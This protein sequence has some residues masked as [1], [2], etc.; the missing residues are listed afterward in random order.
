M[1]DRT[2]DQI[3]DEMI[4]DISEG[5]DGTDVRAGIIGEI[6]T[7][8]PVAD[9]E[10]KVL[11]AAAH[12]QKTT[13]VALNVHVNW[14]GKHGI[15]AIRLLE[16][17][18]VDPARIILSHQDE[19]EKPSLEAYR[20]IAERGAYIE[21]DCFGEEDYADEW[22]YV[23]PRDLQRI[24]WV[25]RIIDAGYIDNLLIS[26]DVCYKTY[27]REYGGYGYDHILRTLVPLFRQHQVTDDEVRHI[28]V[29]NPRRAIS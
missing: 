14:R 23:H 10:K 17:E 7:S 4:R 27:M 29:A 26:Q 28:M 6:G 13:G 21:F 1:S 12:A 20:A 2:V 19:M 11:R 8:H 9:N 18:G 16:S 5:V 22:G 3:A 24:E 25:K 15:E